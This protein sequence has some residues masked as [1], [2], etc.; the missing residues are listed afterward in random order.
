MRDR[1]E[2]DDTTGFLGRITTRSL[3]AMILRGLELD[4][5]YVQKFHV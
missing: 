4:L 1:L 5:S 3:E 2:D